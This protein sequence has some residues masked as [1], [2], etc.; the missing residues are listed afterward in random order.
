MAAGIGCA[1]Y[2]DICRGEVQTGLEMKSWPGVRCVCVCKSM[3]SAVQSSLPSVC[4]SISISSI[5]QDEKRI[6]HTLDFE[7]YNYAFQV[8]FEVCELEKIGVLER[9]RE[10]L[11]R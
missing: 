7:S 6:L 8:F 10:K 1:R 3:S 2:I 5:T 11:C 4:C 9:K